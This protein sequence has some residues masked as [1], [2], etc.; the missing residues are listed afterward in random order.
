MGDVQLNLDGVQLRYGSA[1]IDLTVGEF[2]LLYVLM[3]HAGQVR[4]KRQ[5]VEAVWGPQQ[6]GTT[7]LDDALRRTRHRLTE[8]GLPAALIRTVTNAGYVF[9]VTVLQ[10]PDDGQN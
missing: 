3:T 4:S 7:R 8:V 1:R 2:K 5:L 9:D 6:R 10:Q